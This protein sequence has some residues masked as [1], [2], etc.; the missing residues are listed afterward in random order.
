MPRFSADEMLGSLARWLRLMG[1]DTRYERDG[2]DTDILLRAREEG[3]V[4]LTRD[5][6]L[7]ERAGSQGLYIDVRNLDDQIRQVAT[8]YDL[9]FDEDL[10]RCTA[11]NGE[12]VLIGRQEASEGV[13]EGAL[14]SNEEFFRCKSCGKYYWKGSHWT[15][16][17]KRLEALDRPGQDSSR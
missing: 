2:S 11:C 5:K 13:P 12:L 10:S 8:A 9:V 15:N 4:L 16:I 6:K 1:Y 14:H 17:R 3:R 7:A